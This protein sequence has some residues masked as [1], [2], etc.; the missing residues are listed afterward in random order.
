MPPGQL[1]TQVPVVMSLPAS[2]AQAT[3]NVNEVHAAL[4]QGKQVVLE[5]TGGTMTPEHPYLAA[6]QSNIGG[7][8]AIAG[9]QG[10]LV[11]QGGTLDC[12]SSQLS[13]QGNIR[14]ERMKV[15]ASRAVP[16][17]VAQPY[18]NLEL[19]SCVVQGPGAGPVPSSSIVSSSSGSGS[20]GGASSEQP[21]GHGGPAPTKQGQ[22]LKKQG[23]QRRRAT[24]EDQEEAQKDDGPAQCI[25]VDICASF[26]AHSTVFKGVPKVLYSNSSVSME[27]CSIDAR[28]VMEGAHDLIVVSHAR[29]C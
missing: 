18:S 12:R 13:L 25:C 19:Q 2:H 7:L 22:Q 11:L 4:L 20:G 15:L 6:M 8:L 14:L 3:E 23:K 5:L 9:L 17:F 16:A 21:T 1:Q 26:S 28:G 10:S 24:E 29:R 27:K